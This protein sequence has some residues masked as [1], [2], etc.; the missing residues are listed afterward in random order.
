MNIVDRRPNP[1][2]KSLSNR[3]RFLG[4]RPGRGQVGGAGG[5]CASARSPMS[6]TARRSRSR[7][8][9]SPSRSSTTTAAPAAPTMSSPATRNMCGATKSRGRRA[10]RAAAAREGSPDGG[11]EDA[12]E[13]TLSKDEFLDMFFE[14]LELPDLVKKSL[15]D[16]RGRPAAGRLYRHRQPVQPQHPAHDAEQHGAADRA[17]AAETGRDRSLRRRTRRSPRARRRGRDRAARTRTRTY[18]A[19]QQDHPLYRPDRCALPPLRAG[20]AAEHRSGHVLPD[21]RV[22]LDDRGDEGPRQAVLHAA[23]RVSG[24]A[25]PA[26]RRRLH[27]P[28]QHGRGGRRGDV[29]LQPRDR[30]HGRLDRAR[31]DAGDCPRPLSDRPLEHLRRAGLGRRQLRRGQRAAACR[32]SAARYCRC[33]SISPMSRLATAWAAA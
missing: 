16:T 13:F 18:R 8:A 14:D 23:A 11:G 6:S 4:A 22:G 10:A 5:A 28:Y 15:K 1:K 7:R 3:Q 12:F 27:P 25:L 30:R 19:P 33:A 2:G 17:E 26:C 29:L 9:A 24:A 31:K 32:C 21:G 20:A